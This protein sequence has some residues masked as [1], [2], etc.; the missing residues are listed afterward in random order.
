MVRVAGGRDPRRFGKVDDVGAFWIDRV[1]VTNRQF[2]AFVDGGGYQRRE[3]WREPFL[4]NHRTMT[5]TEA[6]GRFRDR[7]GRPGPATWTAGTYPAGQEEFPVA[8]VSW[9]E[10]MAYAAFAGCF[11]VAPAPVSVARN[12]ATE[13]A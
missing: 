4:D 13:A 3:Y 7:T 10:A 5:W 8:G 1:E 6:V 2:K 11:A 9:Y 12:A